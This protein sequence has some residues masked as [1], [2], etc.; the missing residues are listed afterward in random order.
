MRALEH[1]PS[2]II[3][4]NVDSK[5]GGGVGFIFPKRLELLKESGLEVKYSY[6]DVDDYVLL[7]LCNRVGYH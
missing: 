2:S 3:S 4:S 1:R 5:G 7:M 6:D